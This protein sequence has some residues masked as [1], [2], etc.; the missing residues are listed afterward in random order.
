MHS[1]T[2]NVYPLSQRIFDTFA[3]PRRLAARLRE[4]PHW[5]GPLLISTVAA[6]VAAAA[7]PDEFFLDRTEDPVNRLGRPVT[8]TSSAEEIVRWGRYLQMFS[9][10]VEH[11][12]VVLLFA[13]LITLIFRV[14]GR[15]QV[16]MG[17][18]FALT[19]HAFLISSLGVLLTAGWHVLTGDVEAQ[20]S[21]A[22]ML[23]GSDGATGSPAIRLLSLLNPFTLWMLLVLALGVDHLEPRWSFS[24]AAGVLVGLY[25]AFAVTLAAA[26]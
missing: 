20:P 19:A 10:A 21:L 14:A 15:G 8:V 7:L 16:T 18:Y 2:G 12:M 6:V 11:P 1:S 17:L 9:A 26:G 3:A 22:L 23:G 13:G 24:T 25:L 4:D 5:Q